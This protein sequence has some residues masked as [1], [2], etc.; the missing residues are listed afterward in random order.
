[1]S[2][3][4][5]ADRRQPPRFYQ[6]LLKQA[7]SGVRVSLSGEDREGPAPVLTKQPVFLAEPGLSSKP[8]HEEALQIG[9]KGIEH[10]V[11]NIEGG[12]G[13]G[14]AHAERGVGVGGGPYGV[15]EKYAGHVDVVLT[16]RSAAD[17]PSLLQ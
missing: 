7:I 2:F 10:R 1:M 14:T 15:V 8:L 16:P 11:S 9:R 12:G 5:T 6:R 17:Q 4:G 3:H 13:H